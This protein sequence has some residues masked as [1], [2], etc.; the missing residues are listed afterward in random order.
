LVSGI[1]WV[2]QAQSARL[3]VQVTLEVQYWS[4][5][6][7]KRRCHYNDPLTSKPRV[8]ILTNN[9]DGDVKP[10][11]VKDYVFVVVD[12]AIQ[13]RNFQGIFHISG[14]IGAQHN[15]TCRGLTSLFLILMP[16]VTNVII[17][18][19][20]CVSYMVL[21]ALCCR[22][23]MA[24]P[25][26]PP[27]RAQLHLFLARTTPITRPSTTCP[28]SSYSL[29]RSLIYRVASWPLVLNSGPGAQLTPSCFS[30]LPK[31][32]LFNR[33]VW[34]I[35]LNSKRLPIYTMERLPFLCLFCARFYVVLANRVFVPLTRN[36]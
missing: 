25:L 26:P 8:S 34:C 32:I 16:Y 1:C 4:W 21:T 12:I 11:T 7:K 33:F 24:L 2:Q 23:P 17:G 6:R 22:R 27:S 20:T 5:A 30:H 36:L 29:D 14:S 35:A 10:F 28:F 19:P 31:T 15:F 9:Y 13:S 3:E 18:A